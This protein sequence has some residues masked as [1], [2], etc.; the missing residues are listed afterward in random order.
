MFELMPFDRRSGSIFNYFDSLEKE[1]FQN[2][3]TTVSA[4]RTDIL[5]EDDKF[6]VKAELPGMNKED[7]QISVDE[8]RLTV[9]ACHK[10]ETEE[11]KN[12][13][14]RRER[15]EGSFQ[16]SFD[17]TGIDA[18]KIE[19]GYKDGVLTLHLPKAAPEAKPAYSIAVK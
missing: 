2:M 15:R 7:I 16:R 9:C 17:I 10:Q 6:V 3:N 1:L 4:I 12:N 18:S 11:K 5:E 19:A 8:N 13:Y 14:I